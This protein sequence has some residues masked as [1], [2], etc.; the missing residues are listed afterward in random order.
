MASPQP[1]PPTPPPSEDLESR[2]D[3]L[4]EDVRQA[5]D[6]GEKAPTTGEPEGTAPT[7]GSA[8]TSDDLDNQ[9]ADLLQ[10]VNEEPSGPDES[11][12]AVPAP[13]AAE[14]AA[15]LPAGPSDEKK[16]IGA[17]DADLARLTDSLLQTNAPLPEVGPGPAPEPTKK[18][19]AAPAT[20]QPSAGPTPKHQPIKAADPELASH[21]RTPAI[22]VG[23]VAAPLAH[24]LV[25]SLGPGVAKLGASVGHLA[26]PAVLTVLAAASAPLAG[27]P[28][29]VR[30]T[31]GWLA[32]W[33]AFISLNLWT[34]LFFFHKPEV[35]KADNAPIEFV[36]E[37]GKPKPEKALATAPTEERAQAEGGHGE[38]P[39]A[40]GH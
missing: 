27:R 22:P 19:P 12:P 1:T 24:R 37:M 36:G 34:Y 10:S 6:A 25:G 17:L 9:I 20:V 7:A 31:V 32:V 15:E 29:V 11:A 14:V 30:D 28:N 18:A 26:A 4:L 38:A 5:Q 23:P 35:P 39:A 21:D 8:T 16:D 3:A 13:P 40:S 2:V 33:T